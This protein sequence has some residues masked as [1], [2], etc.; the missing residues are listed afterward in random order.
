M[1]KILRTTFFREIRFEM[2][3]VGTVKIT[4]CEKHANHKIVNQK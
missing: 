2:R 1:L 4:K 3:H